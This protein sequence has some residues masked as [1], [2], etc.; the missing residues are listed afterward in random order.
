MGFGSRLFFPQALALMP[1]DAMVGIITYGAMVMLHELGGG[2]GEAQDASCG[3]AMKAHVF[4]G[5][6]ELTPLKVG[7]S[8]PG[9][10][11]F[12]SLFS[13][14]VCFSFHPFIGSKS[15]SV[16]LCFQNEICLLSLVVA[17]GTKKTSDCVKRRGTFEM[18]GVR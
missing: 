2:D 6:K 12:L 16:S 10:S 15:W 5:N 14:V 17:T 18:F 4:R 9:V 13:K 3:E 1:S 8:V 7:L 11:C